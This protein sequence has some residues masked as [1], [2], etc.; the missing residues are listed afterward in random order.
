MFEGPEWEQFV[1]GIKILEKKLINLV[2]ENNIS[3]EEIAKLKIVQEDIGGLRRWTAILGDRYESFTIPTWATYQSNGRTVD[4]DELAKAV[5]LPIRH[6]LIKKY[7]GLEE[8]L[9][10]TDRSGRMRV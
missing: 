2:E 10:E 6:T 3:Y 7:E 1:G 9:T 5:V 4:Y 8:S